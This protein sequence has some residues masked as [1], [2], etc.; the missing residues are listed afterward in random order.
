VD[1]A[2]R[3]VEKEMTEA[4][5]VLTTEFKHETVSQFARAYITGKIRISP[6]DAEDSNQKMLIRAYEKITQHLTEYF[7]S[8][9]SHKERAEVEDQLIYDIAWLR[10]NHLIQ[11]DTV[12]VTVMQ[13]EINRLHERVDATNDLLSATLAVVKE[14]V[15]RLD[16]Q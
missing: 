15:V 8:S 9:Q 13:D 5:E 12:P 14:L 4:D 11:E 3:G 6:I 7:S 16:R 2:T 10:G 1:K